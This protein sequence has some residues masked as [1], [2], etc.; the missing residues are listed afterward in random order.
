MPGLTGSSGTLLT[1][2]AIVAGRRAFTSASMLL[3]LPEM[4]T[5]M[6]FVLMRSLDDGLRLA[7]PPSGDHPDAPYRLAALSVRSIHAPL[8]DCR[9]SGDG[10]TPQPREM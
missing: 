6:R 10:L 4:S 5:T 2:P 9:A 3:P 8:L 1:T 7:G